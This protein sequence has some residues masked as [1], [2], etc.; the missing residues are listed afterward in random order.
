[1]TMTL[2]AL[3]VAPRRWRPAVAAVGGVFTVAVAFSLLTRAWHMPSDVIGGFLLAA[4]WVSAAVAALAWAEARDPRRAPSRPGR[5][6]PREGPSR[7][8]APAGRE[9]LVPGVVLGSVAGVALGV[10]ALRPAEV[11]DFAATHHSVV[12]FAAVIAALAA[13]LVSGFTV[14]LRR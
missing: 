13:S 8:P 11:A 9:A 3:L 2:S 4:L 6:I 14:A 7:R 10:V 1:M 5:R 12:A